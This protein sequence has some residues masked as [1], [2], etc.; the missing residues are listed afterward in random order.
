MSAFERVRAPLSTF[1]FSR[2]ELADEVDE[3]AT[4]MRVLGERGGLP[5]DTLAIMFGKAISSNAGFVCLDGK[6]LAAFG[7]KGDA[8]TGGGV[9]MLTANAA[10]LPLLWSEPELVVDSATNVSGCVEEL[11]VDPDNLDAPRQYESV[12]T[13]APC[14]VLAPLT[15]TKRT[16]MDC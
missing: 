7:G 6:T 3:Y 4:T 9:S 13:V 5:G 14:V 1:V 16:L 12:P 2:L 8:E 15:I 11:Q 10:E